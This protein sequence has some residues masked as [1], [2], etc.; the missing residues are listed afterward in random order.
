MLGA[1][2]AAQLRLAIVEALYPI[3]AHDLDEV[4]TALGLEPPREDE[5]PFSSKRRYVSR[6]LYGFSFSELVDLARKIEEQHDVEELSQLLAAVGVTGVDGDLKNIIFAANGP[7]PR[8]ILR[9]AINNVI[10]IVE[11]AEHC[12]VYDRPLGPHG[13][14]WGDRHPPQPRSNAARSPPARPAPS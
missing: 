6:R 11:N 13:L 10:D 3:S 14:T 9:D 7:K 1:A 12:L 8:I 4:C 2:T 5:S